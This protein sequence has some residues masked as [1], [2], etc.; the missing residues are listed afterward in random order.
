MILA[1][2][3]FTNY[4]HL[5]SFSTFIASVSPSPVL[6]QEANQPENRAVRP[7]IITMAHR[8]MY[9]SDD[10]QDDCT[11]FDSYVCATQSTTQF[12]K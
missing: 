11:K 9:C 2:L 6:P 8:P 10:D 4:S 3:F 5:S 7:W 12:L 1:F